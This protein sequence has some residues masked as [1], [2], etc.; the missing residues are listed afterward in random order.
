MNESDIAVFVTVDAMFPAATAD[1]ACMRSAPSRLSRDV[2]LLLVRGSTPSCRALA[3]T[4]RFTNVRIRR[5]ACWRYR[6]EAY[7][8]KSQCAIERMTAYDA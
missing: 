7:T 3:P 1:E 4:A 8:P 2:A 6:S 5:S